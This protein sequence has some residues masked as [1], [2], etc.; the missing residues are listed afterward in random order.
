M[1]L[2]RKVF[3]IMI[4]ATFMLPCILTNAFGDDVY[5][6]GEKALC[7]IGDVMRRVEVHYYEND[8]P[9]PCEVHYYKET[10]EP[11]E[12]RVLWRAESETGYCENK[13]TAFV[14]ELTGFGW[15]C[16]SEGD[17]PPALQLGDTSGFAR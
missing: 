12:D 16:E 5:R 1:I 14:G 15:Y 8:K 7:S 2:I 10:E 3:L 17:I 11:G 9:V 6:Q 13:M 4:L